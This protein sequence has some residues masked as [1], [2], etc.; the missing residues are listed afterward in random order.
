MALG[1]SG[2]L[3]EGALNWRPQVDKHEAA[4]I[5]AIMKM[6][7]GSVSHWNAPSQI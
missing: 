4:Y 3:P 1:N 5:M 2:K 7:V 6:S